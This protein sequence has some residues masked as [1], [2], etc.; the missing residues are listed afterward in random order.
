MTCWLVRVCWAWRIR[1]G[2]SSREPTFSS[3]LPGRSKPSSRLLSRFFFFVWDFFS[4]VKMRVLNII[5]RLDVEVYE[6]VNC[7]IYCDK[8]IYGQLFLFILLRR[9]EFLFLICVVNNCLIVGF[10]SY[11]F[12]RI[13]FVFF[14]FYW[15]F[16]GEMLIVLFI[17]VENW[18]G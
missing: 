16:W 10:F 11:L 17:I 3:S 9:N 7:F 6:Y 15:R 2:E 8:F 14:C 5:E 4:F 12:V 13:K 18:C 1:G